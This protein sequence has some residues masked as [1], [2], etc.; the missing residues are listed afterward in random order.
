LQ[1]NYKLITNCRI[2]DSSQLDSIL[3]LGNQPLA[4]ALREI[5]DLNEEIYIP[6]EVIRCE[7]CTTVQLSVNVDPDI[8]FKEYFWVTGTTKTATDHLEKLST[9]I[10]ERCVKKNPSLL[11]VGSN[12]GSLLK[13]LKKRDFGQ[14]YGVDPAKNIVDSINEPKIIFYTDF[15]NYS[16]AKSFVEFNGNLDIVV[17]RNVFSHVPDLVDCLRGVSSL[18]TEDGLFVIEFHEATKIVTEIHYDSIYH[19]HTFYHSIKS[20][21]EAAKIVGLNSFDI[22]ISPISGGSL[23]LFLSKKPK[24][25]TISLLEHETSEEKSGV[26]TIEKWNEFAKKS[27]KNLED[28]RDYLNENTGRKLCGFGAS[29]RSSTLIN[30]IGRECQNIIGIADNNPLKQG[31]LSPGTHLQ[32]ESPKKLITSN[33]DIVVVFPFNFEEEIIGFLKNI[34]NWSGEV[35][36]PLPNTPRVIKI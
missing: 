6:L 29:A 2:C 36:L 7:N 25:K 35:Y 8:M 30:A 33:I 3:N 17:A 15:F 26:L 19:E 23:I 13:I 10:S 14:L 20:I 28:I 5:D 27:L 1:T 34:L 24:N 4:N 21:S 31:K 11:E 18:L 16:F 22:E 32:I 9:F 12:D